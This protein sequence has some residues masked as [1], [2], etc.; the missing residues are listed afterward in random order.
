[1]S[2]AL[3]KWLARARKFDKKGFLRRHSFVFFIA[4][5]LFWSVGIAAPYA[6]WSWSRFLLP[7]VQGDTITTS[8]YADVRAFGTRTLSVL[9]GGLLRA[10][11]NTANSSETCV[12]APLAFVRRPANEPWSKA[13][14]ELLS[15][16]VEAHAKAPPDDARGAVLGQ[17]WGV[18]NSTA[19]SALDCYLDGNGDP[20]RA[21]IAAGLAVTDDRACVAAATKECGI[22]NELQ[23]AARASQRGLW[24][25]GFAVNVMAPR[26]ESRPL[27]RVSHPVRPVARP[28]Q[29]VSPRIDQTPLDPLGVRALSTLPGGLLHAC[30]KPADNSESCIAAPL[31]FIR[32]PASEPWA[33]IG[34]RLLSK[35]LEPPSKPKVGDEA[36]RTATADC[37]AVGL[38]EKPSALD[39]DLDGG[40]NPSRALVSAGFAITDSACSQKGQVDKI[41]AIKCG[42]LENLQKEARALRHGLWW[43]G[44]EDGQSAPD[45]VAERWRRDAI[46]A[47]ALTGE[48]T[49]A[50]LVTGAMPLALG[51]VAGFWYLVHGTVEGYNKRKMQIEGDLEQITSISAHFGAYAGGSSGPEAI[52]EAISDAKRIY[53]PAIRNRLIHLLNQYK[54]EPDNTNFDNLME[55]LD[56]FQH[57]LNKH[58]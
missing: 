6:V 24:R 44:L 50:A 8:A 54:R 17:C 41:A 31:A 11:D 23:A 38:R 20:R 9:P 21:L 26:T 58:A 46:A 27:R 30:T 3:K 36:R 2:P 56:K 48:Q 19:P 51:L 43:D 37:W 52:K 22:L 4:C 16:L 5:A 49:T 12:V 25:D 15:K 47:N 57:E 40:D 45:P 55:A 32:R 39:C 14:D 42:D 7:K 18:G 35:L 1:M 34:E 10:C 13:G 29:P 28:V 33:G 53:T